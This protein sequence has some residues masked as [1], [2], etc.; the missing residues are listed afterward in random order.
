VPVLDPSRR[1]LP[2]PFHAAL[3]GAPHNV[4]A[5][6]QQFPYQSSRETTVLLAVV[7]LFETA[8]IF[9]CERGVEQLLQR[10]RERDINPAIVDVHRAP[11]A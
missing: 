2:T 6:A 8:R 7:P 5:A 3:L 11:V 9:A 10:F 1:E 4:D